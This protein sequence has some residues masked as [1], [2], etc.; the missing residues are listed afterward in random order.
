MTPSGMPASSAA[1]LRRR[2]AARRAATAASS[3]SRPRRL[4]RRRNAADGG[5]ARGVAA[6]PAT[7]ASRPVLVGQRAPG[8]EV[9][10]PL[11]LALPVRRVRRA[12]GRPRVA[13]RSSSSQ[14]GPLRRPGGVPVQRVLGVERSRGAAQAVDL[15][16]ARP[17][18]VGVL[19]DL[20]DAQVER[21]GEAAA[22]SAGT[23]RAPSGATVSAACS[24]LTSTKP[25]PSSAAQP[26]R[27]ARSARS[28]T[29]QDGRE[30]TLVELRDQPHTRSV[31]QH[32]PAAGAAAAVTISVRTRGLRPRTAHAAGG[33][34][35]AG[36]PA[37]GTS[38]RRRARRRPPAGSTQLSLAA[39]VAGGRRPPG[40]PTPRRRSPCGTCTANHGVQPSRITTR[41]RQHPAPPRG[42]PP[43]RGAARPPGARVHPERGAARPPPSRAVTGTCRPCQSQYS[44]AIRCL[45]ARSSSDWSAGPSG[46]KSAR[47]C[48]TQG[49]RAPLGRLPGTDLLAHR[50][51]RLGGTH[52]QHDRPHTR[53]HA[54]AFAQP[55]PGRDKT[56]YLYVAV[57]VAV[58][59]GI[60]V[61][62][63]FEDFAIQLQWLGDAFVALIKMMI[64]PVIFCTLVLGIGTVRSAASVGKVGGLALGL[65]P[66][67]VD[68]RAGHRP[69]RRQPDPP[70]RGPQPL[71]G[72]REGRLGAGRRCRVHHRVHRRHR[73]RLAAVGTHLGRGAADP[74]GRPA[75]R[76]RAAGD[77]PRRRADPGRRSST[78]SASSSACSR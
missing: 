20:L 77:G 50:R 13:R 19:V 65:L 66:R 30:R 74:A 34:P 49:R 53:A 40:R 35:A 15:G 60:V 55:S 72:A 14:R 54:F 29:P 31:A 46:G 56:H 75:R 64:Q 12:P 23:A 39:D 67:D 58:I 2:R 42:A 21:V 28:P 78:S 24:G 37:A 7:C 48:P 51:T 36:R 73:A 38:P 61:G 11:A 59:L 63:L 8:G 71:R 69:R 76:L 9:D 33:S 4:V 25:A 18:Q 47:Q 68:G 41:R 70:W 32:A 45:A 1:R 43:R 27:S 3:G 57:V 44:V 16:A 52:E 26:A 10:Q 5:A 6:P 62:L 22:W 17:A